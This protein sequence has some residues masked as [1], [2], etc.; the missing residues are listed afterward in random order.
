LTTVGILKEE[1]QYDGTIA[2]SLTR[3]GLLL[4][5][6]RGPP[7]MASCIQHWMEQPLWDAW[8]ELPNYIKEGTTSSSLPF[9]RANGGVSSDFYYNAQDHPESL[10]HANDFVRLIHDNEIQAVVNGFDW[11]SLANKNSNQRLVDIGGHHGKVI[12]A[13]AQKNPS[14]DCVCLDLPEVIAS[15]PSP[16]KGS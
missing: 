14:L 16:I 2:F 11:A 9:D 15:A 12:G 10:K 6:G 4:R 5:R 7:S 13:I 1:E 3:T 8:L